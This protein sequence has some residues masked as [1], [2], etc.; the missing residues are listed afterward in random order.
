MDAVG[1]PDRSPSPGTPSEANNA[2]GAQTVSDMS[3]LQRTQQR[4]PA[5]TTITF[6]YAEDLR[7]PDSR[8]PWALGTAGVLLGERGARPL[9]VLGRPGENTGGVLGRC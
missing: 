9:A 7:E 5:T 2:A 8:Q 3:R 4:T 1:R 6:A